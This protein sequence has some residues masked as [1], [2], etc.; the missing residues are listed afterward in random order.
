MGTFSGTA[1][2]VSYFIAAALFILGL[3]RMSSPVTARSGI[4]WAGVGMIVATLITFL[5]PDMGNYALMTVAIAVGSIAAWVTGR[6]VAMADMPQTGTTGNPEAMQKQIVAVSLASGVLSRFTAYVA[7]DRSEVVNQG[8][9]QQQI[10][11]PVEMPEGWVEAEML[12]CGAAPAGGASDSMRFLAREPRS[13]S[14][15]Q[16]KATPAQAQLRAFAN[17]PPAP[18]SRSPQDLVA[19][20]ERLIQPVDDSGRLDLRFRRTGLT[21]LIDLLVRIVAQVKSSPN[22]DV[23]LVAT[24]DDLIQ[25]SRELLDDYN[26][27][28]RAALAA[29]PLNQLFE[30]VR[31]TLA[32]LGPTSAA[33]QP[34]D[35]RGRF[36]T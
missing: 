21:R 15:K 22:A 35:S 6:R 14:L 33:T 27:G 9:R 18:K 5:T 25:R 31:Q 16:R 2:Q 1:I 13:A 24:L 8:G 4:V 11:Q 17:S 19:E 28:N 20:I 10:V 34:S 26:G 30:A 32:R 29:G 12:Y 23:D 7:V 3:K 36:W